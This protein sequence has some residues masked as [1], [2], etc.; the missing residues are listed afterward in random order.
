MV[1]VRIGR[2]VEAVVDL[3]SCT[4]GG[5]SRRAL[6]ELPSMMDARQLLGMG[7]EQLDMEY[8]EGDCTM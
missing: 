4:V 1:I 2:S 8:L 5:F 6:A 3:I 7:M